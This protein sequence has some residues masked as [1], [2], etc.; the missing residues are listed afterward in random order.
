MGGRLAV[1]AGAGVVWLISHKIML[2]SLRN[3]KD[4]NDRVKQPRWE[5]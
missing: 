5:I 3:H 4:A 1:G 2:T